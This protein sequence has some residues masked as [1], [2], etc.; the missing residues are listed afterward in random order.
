MISRFF[1]AYKYYLK[2]DLRIFMSKND[3]RIRLN[4]GSIYVLNNIKWEEDSVSHLIFKYG[5]FK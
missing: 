5:V 2:M 1:W 4:D 3:K